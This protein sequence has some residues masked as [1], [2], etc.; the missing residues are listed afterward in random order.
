MCSSDLN[1]SN[2]FVGVGIRVQKSYIGP[3]ALFKD[4]K[5]AKE[6]QIVIGGFNLKFH[7]IE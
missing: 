1:L 5:Y 4:V 3:W 7:S 2:P 6:E